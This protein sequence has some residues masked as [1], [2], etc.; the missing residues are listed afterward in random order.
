M[1][2]SVHW[3]IYDR[4]DALTHYLFGMNS[5]TV[6]MTCIGTGIFAFQNY[7]NTQ[8]LLKRFNKYSDYYFCDPEDYI[9]DADDQT[10]SYIK[11]ITKCC[12]IGSFLFVISRN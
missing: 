6:G 8:Y 5:L 9:D 10:W 7:Q 11:I 2:S 1:E 4:W 3:W 12:I